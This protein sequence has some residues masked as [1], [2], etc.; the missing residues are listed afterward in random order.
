MQVCSGR[1]TCKSKTPP[2]HNTATSEH[3]KYQKILQF[4]RKF[5]KKMPRCRF[6]DV[7][8]A[9]PMEMTDLGKIFS[10]LPTL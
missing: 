2:Q 10:D 9:E 8:G 5:P 1:V 7:P 3:F 6:Q 4:L